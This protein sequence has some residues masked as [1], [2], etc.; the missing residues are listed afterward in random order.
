MNY[1]MLFL[2]SCT[3]WSYALLLGLL[4]HVQLFVTLWTVACQAPLSMGFSRQEYWSGLPFP[5]PGDLSDPGIKL[6]SPAL[7]GRFFTPKQPGKPD[8]MLSLPLISTRKG[9]DIIMVEIWYFVH[10]ILCF[11]DLQ[12]RASHL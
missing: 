3:V 6:A 7:A 11:F 4:S 2:L 5:P 8:T 12:V 10:R 9:V 1:Q